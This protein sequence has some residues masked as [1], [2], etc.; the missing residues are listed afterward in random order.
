MIGVNLDLDKKANEMTDEQVDE[1]NAHAAKHLKR[2]LKRLDKATMSDE[3]FLGRCYA[4]MVAAEAI[5]WN[6]ST[7]CLV[8]VDRAQTLKDKVK[9]AN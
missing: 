2:V 9:D 3:E 1:I 4:Y 5:G 6:V 7:M 8:A